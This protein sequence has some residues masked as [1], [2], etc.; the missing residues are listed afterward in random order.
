MG[1]SIAE[2]LAA[3]GADVTL[4]SGPVHLNIQHPHIK[5][6]DVTSADEMY[7]SCM[8]EKETADIIVMAAAVADYKPVAQAASK[9][10]KSGSD[11]E[12]KLNTYPRYPG[13]NRKNK[14]ARS[15][16]GRF[17]P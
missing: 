5:R 2:E 1:F 10:K 12:I 15:D 7:D 3:M 13:R 4:V 6:I 14:K 8:A 11:L 9:L 17:C 16:T